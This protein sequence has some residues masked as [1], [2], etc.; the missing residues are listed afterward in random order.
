[1]EG[2][3]KLHR[4]IT[5]WDWYDDANTFRLFIHLL[6]LAN[7]K[8]AKWR[9]VIIRRGEYLTGRKVLAEE[10]KISEQAIRTSLKHLES[11]NEIAIKSTNKFSII[12]ICK[13]ED[14]QGLQPDNQPTANHQLTNGQPSTNHK[15]EGKEGKEIKEEEVVEENIFIPAIKKEDST[16]Y[17]EIVSLYASICK[18]YP[19]L[20]IISPERKSKMK[21]RFT[22]MKNIETVKTIF[23]K[24]EAS[25]YLQGDNKRGW[26]ATF[27]W[28]FENSKNW[29]KIFEG[30]YD[31]RKPETGKFKNIPVV[32][33]PVVRNYDEQF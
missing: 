5:E 1:M 21:I 32:P 14:Y 10:L 29:V 7:S 24:M 4:K 19:A 27:D 30:N 9:G 18:C 26:K 25:K 31:N 23:E 8:D 12:T 16:P 13:Y 20:K 2:W 28:V 33:V 6:L 3:I 11:T 17:S 22:E 15:Q